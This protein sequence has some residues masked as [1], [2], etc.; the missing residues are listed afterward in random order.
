MKS[1]RDRAIDVVHAMM[2]GGF[3]R[4]TFLVMMADRGDTGTVI[5]KWVDAVEAGVEQ[6]RR[7]VAAAGKPS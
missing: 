3:G 1:A 6:D 4:D 7:E 2:G 5:R